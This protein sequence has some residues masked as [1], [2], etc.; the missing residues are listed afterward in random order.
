MCVTDFLC[1]TKGFQ[2]ALLLMEAEDLNRWGI[3]PGCSPE[4]KEA[5]YN[6]YKWPN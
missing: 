4:K 1:N 6:V 3:E 2:K 5:E